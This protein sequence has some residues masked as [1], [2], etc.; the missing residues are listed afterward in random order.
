MDNYDAPDLADVLAHMD[1]ERDIWGDGYVCLRRVSVNRGS[2][3]AI[4]ASNSLYTPI[5]PSSHYGWS[6][7]ITLNYPHGPYVVQQGYLSPSFE[8]Y[9]RMTFQAINPTWFVSYDS[10]RKLLIDI[11]CNPVD[12][13]Y[14]IEKLG[15]LAR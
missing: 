11:G 8:Y 3:L 5:I 2:A 12:V 1:L 4:I 7:V 14:K 10:L 9:G 6:F 15:T 13:E